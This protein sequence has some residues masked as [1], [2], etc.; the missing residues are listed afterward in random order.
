M[1]HLEDKCLKE[2]W[3][4]HFALGKA[5]FM[6]RFESKIFIPEGKNLGFGAQRVGAITISITM[7]D[8]F[9]IFITWDLQNYTS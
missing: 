2:H 4:F 9:R 7:N 1:L 3:N 5:A 6:A 8:S